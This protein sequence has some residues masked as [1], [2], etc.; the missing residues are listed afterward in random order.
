MVHLLL[1]KGGTFVIVQQIEHVGDE[2]VD[3]SELT[4]AF[5]KQGA[6]FVP[7]GQQGIGLGQRDSLPKDLR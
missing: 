4:V 6:C 3:V 2:I 1:V 7:F 5:V